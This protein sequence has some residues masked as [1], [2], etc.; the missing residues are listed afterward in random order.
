MVSIS[1]MIFFSFL[2]LFHI[3]K[4]RKYVTNIKF[5]VTTIK[6]LQIL[7]KIYRNYP[8]LIMGLSNFNDSNTYLKNVLKNL[9]Y[10]SSL[11]YEDKMLIFRNSLLKQYPYIAPL[12]H[13]I[14]EDKSLNDRRTA[15]NKAIEIFQSSAFSSKLR[16]TITLAMSGMTLA[17][18]PLTLLVLFY[19]QNILYLL[20]LVI[21]FFYGVMLYLNFFIMKKSTKIFI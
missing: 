3:K 13:D 8:S 18:I 19:Q 9:L 12:L 4:L 17:P 1:L 2:F 16:N 21:T 20:P 14:L 7:A 6:L 5:D 10:K 15:L 11:G